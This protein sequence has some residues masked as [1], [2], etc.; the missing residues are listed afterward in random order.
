[1]SEILIKAKETLSN[2]KY[3]EEV[4]NQ[5][6]N[7]ISE[8]K[9]KLNKLTDLGLNLEIAN[10]TLSSYKDNYKKDII[11]KLEQNLKDTINNWY[12]GEY[13]FKILEDTKKGITYARLIDS[14]KGSNLGL[15]CGDACSS[16]LQLLICI[17]IL[18]LQ[19]K[20][21]N[22]FMFID[23]RF[24]KFST[25]KVQLVADIIEKSLEESNTQVALVEHKYNIITEDDNSITYKVSMK[26][27]I[28]S[29]TPIHNESLY[30]DLLSEIKEGI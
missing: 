16:T 7:E 6:K 5:I 4:N 2:W 1:M 11:T 27:G 19:S 14:K 8:I 22:D 15:I 12:N 17:A 28:S 20:G 18:K 21:Y 26:N 30:N 13:D 24:S 29:I 9:I 25:D 3:Q 10:R 23:E